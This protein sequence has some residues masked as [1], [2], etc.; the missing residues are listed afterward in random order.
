METPRRR[1]FRSVVEIPLRDIVRGLNRAPE[2]SAEVL[3]RAL[4]AAAPGLVDAI[5]RSLR[6]GRPF[7]P[8]R[9]PESFPTAGEIADA[10]A[11]V[12]G[13]DGPGAEVAARV[14]GAGVEHCLAHAEHTALIYSETVA[15]F[16]L[17]RLAHRERGRTAAAHAAQI[18]L[19]LGQARAAGLAPGLPLPAPPEAEALR[20]RVLVAAALWLMAEPPEVPAQEPELIEVCCILARAS[21]DRIDAAGEAEDA[22][23]TLLAELAEIV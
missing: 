9:L 14:I 12:A 10:R 13:C 1:H 3:Q 8:P 5:R 16:A 22:L 2:L 23:A 4:P 21:A 19:A 20:R 18:V 6:A 15:A 17:A 7:A 11:Y